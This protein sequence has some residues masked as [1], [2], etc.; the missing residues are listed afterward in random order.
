MGTIDQGFRVKL[1]LG[2]F[3]LHAALATSALV[4]SLDRGSVRVPVFWH[5][6][7]W[8]RTHCEAAGYPRDVQVC[9]ASGDNVAER[10]GSVNFTMVLIASQT[11]TC[12]FHLA[13][14]LQARRWHSNYIQWSLVRGIKVW[15]W[16]E[17]TFTAAL[18]AHTIL[19]FS[20]MLSIRTQLIGYAAQ[21]T[22]MLHGSSTRRLCT[23]LCRAAIPLKSW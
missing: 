7:E 17:Y 18:L 20:G 5:R 8:N 22:L 11:I 12:A 19:Y 3:G 13:Q 15:H 1:F 21:S 10:A 23:C 4:S 16:V 6:S 9:P 2:H 14:A